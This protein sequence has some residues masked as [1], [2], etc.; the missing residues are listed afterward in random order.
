[1]RKKYFIILFSLFFP[2]QIFAQ[3]VGGNRFDWVA[4]SIVD[5]LSSLSLSNDVSEETNL[6]ET[7]TLPTEGFGG[8]N[9]TV[10][11]DV[12]N[13]EIFP[14]LVVTSS[15]TSM[16][17]APPIIV[18]QGG[19]E[20][21]DG[22]GEYNILY[23]IFLSEGDEVILNGNSY[24]A[25]SS[26]KVNF[27][28]DNGTEDFQDISAPAGYLVLVMKDL[29][30]NYIIPEGGMI[31]EYAYLPISTGEYSLLL[32]AMIYLMLIYYR[33]KKQSVTN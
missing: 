24:V 17:S 23:D 15:S 11:D 19:T 1:V 33:R 8:E 21:A 5:L 18:D 10:S 12:S 6:T 25:V 32:F 31:F 9:Y 16:L 20:F 28:G 3:E 13:E 27:G 22:A 29:A 14:S 2:F 26:A 7:P 30:G 4:T